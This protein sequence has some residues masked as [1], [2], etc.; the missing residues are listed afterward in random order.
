[1][2]LMEET[3]VG[4]DTFKSLREKYN[5]PLP[6][7][8]YK[9]P[10]LI[11]TFPRTADAVRALDE[12]LNQLNDEELKGYEFVKAQGDVN[13][14]EYREKFGYDTKKAQRHLTKFK[15]LGLVLPVGMG[16]SARYKL[17]EGNYNRDINQDTVS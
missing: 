12:K 13:N 7:I 2:R 4:M 15:I 1:M 11:V 17:N 3:R 8:L 16:R 10:Y 14:T 6:V 5:L 9:N